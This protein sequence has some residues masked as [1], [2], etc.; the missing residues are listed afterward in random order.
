MPNGDW[1]RTPKGKANRNYN[2]L[3]QRLIAKGL[4]LNV[5]PEDF[6]VIYFKATEC[7][8]CGN[9]FGA[10]YGTLKSIRVAGYGKDKIVRP[11]HIKIVHVTC[12]RL[13]NQNARKN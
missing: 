11:E 7:A 3:K 4:T 13:G 6:Y 8:I 2:K 1:G 5:R 9:K 10:M 12:N